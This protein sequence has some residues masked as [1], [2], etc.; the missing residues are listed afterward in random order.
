MIQKIID[1][2]KRRPILVGLALA[3]LLLVILF[4][5][6]MTPFVIALVVVYLMEPFVR[7]MNQRGIRK[8]KLPRGLAVIITYLVFLSL[9]VGLSFA[10]IPSVATEINLATE[11][12]PRYYKDFKD[13]VLPGLSAKVDRVLFTI[14]VRDRTELAEAVSESRKIINDAF[15]LAVSEQNANTL[16]EVDTSGAQPLLIL[17]RERDPVV[18]S[19]KGVK[20]AETDQGEVL[21]RL[22]KSPNSDEFYVLAG[23]LDIKLEADSKGSFTIKAK[24]DEVGTTN[25]TDFNLERE[26]NRIVPNLLESSTQYAGS[27]LSILQ[28]AVEFVIN[29]FVQLI[30]VFMLAAFISIDL[31]KLMMRLRTLF[32]SSD[33]TTDIFDDL[34]KRLT[35]GLSGVIRGQLTICLIN[36]TL[37]GVGLWIIGVDFALLLGIIA[38]VLSIVP[39]FGTIISTIPAVLLGLVQ[40]PSSGLFVLLWILFVHFIDANFFTPKIVG[41][42]ASLH[43]VVIIFALLAGQSAFG[44]LGLIFAV[45][46]ASIC[47]TLFLFM[48]EHVRRSRSESQVIPAVSIQS[49][50][51]RYVERHSQQNMQAIQSRS[52]SDATTI[53]DGIDEK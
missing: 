40:G 37:T 6:V 23:D 18:I 27:A 28:Y 43:P 34:L 3:L 29:T 2:L 32:E 24:R 31:P 36:G 50:I 15:D 10:L 51:H 7:R 46:I 20:K 25:P 39:I 48:L 53:P 47:Q 13:E 45:P 41:S 5:Q 12:L 19:D 16:P 26:L 8:H 11:A 52:D 21:L 44:A 38:G 17:G 42:S 22:R 33:G 49:S 9:L 1:F 14:A 30:L 4:H 35:K